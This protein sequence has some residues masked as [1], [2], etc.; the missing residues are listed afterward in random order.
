[1]ELNGGQNIEGKYGKGRRMGGKGHFTSSAHS[2]QP[3]P[4]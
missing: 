4:K 1:M 2:L 3:Q